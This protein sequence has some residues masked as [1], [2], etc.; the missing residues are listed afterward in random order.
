[1]IRENETKKEYLDKFRENR[2][3]VKRIEEQIKE[4][5]VFETSP[6]INSMDVKIHGSSVTKDLSAYIVKNNEL[7]EKMLQ[8]RYRRLSTYSEIFQAIEEVPDERERQVLTLRYIKGL[9]WEEIAVEMHVEWAQVHRIH[10]RA[11]GHFKI[12]T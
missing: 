2:D 4:F 12:P 7:V 10:A 8:A 1:M 9:K 11:L 5:E 6:K 3:A